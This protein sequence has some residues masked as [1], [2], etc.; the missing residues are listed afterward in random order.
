VRGK[1]WVGW[2]NARR[3]R[4][5]REGLQED[6]AGAGGGGGTCRWNKARIGWIGKDWHSD[7]T[8]VELLGK[9]TDCTSHRNPAVGGVMRAGGAETQ[10]RTGPQAGLI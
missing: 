5:E 2:N 4:Q 7:E 6:M 1:A 8:S 3:P 9:S 10:E